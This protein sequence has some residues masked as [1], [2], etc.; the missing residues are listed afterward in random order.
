MGWVCERGEWRICEGD[1]GIFI[2]SK[3]LLQV[4]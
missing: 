4:S 1:V 2:F 3:Y